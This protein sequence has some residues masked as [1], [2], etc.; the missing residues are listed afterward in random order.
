M[1]VRCTIVCYLSS[2]RRG[3]S[4]AKNVP[5]RNEMC[6]RWVATRPFVLPCL[7]ARHIIKWLAIGSYQVLISIKSNDLST[8]EIDALRNNEAPCLF[9][10]QISRSFPWQTNDFPILVPSFFLR[11]HNKCNVC[12]LTLWVFL[13]GYFLYWKNVNCI[14]I[15]TRL[16]G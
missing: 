1:E 5:L 13:T 7:G 8:I 15:Y 10:I 12:T 16:R 6:N 2:S 14:K 3:G 11:F 9:R 4:L